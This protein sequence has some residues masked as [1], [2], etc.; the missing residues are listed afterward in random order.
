[1][2]NKFINK[3]QSLNVLPSLSNTN[4]RGLAFVAVPNST[5]AV[6]LVGSVSSDI[7]KEVN[8]YLELKEHNEN[9][10]FD[11]QLDV[12]E[13]AGITRTVNGVEESFRNSHMWEYFWILSEFHYSNATKKY[14]NKVDNKTIWNH[15]F[16]LCYYTDNWLSFEVAS[17]EI[18]K[19]RS[20]KFMYNSIP[21]PPIVLIGIDRKGM[22]AHPVKADEAAVLASKYGVTFI[23][24]GIENRKFTNQDIYTSIIAARP[25]SDGSEKA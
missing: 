4:P 8:D 25:P 14:P 23:E 22:S 15:V 24:T 18:G 11:S 7:L 2:F 5:I 10:S 12:V 21:S 20:L 13:S 19:L 3:V 1:M 17:R 16:A 9:I 6:H